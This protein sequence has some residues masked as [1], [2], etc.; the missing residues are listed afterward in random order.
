MTAKSDRKVTRSAFTLVELLVVIAIMAALLGLLLPAVQY[1]RASAR[2]TQ[3]LSQLHNIGIAMDNYMD[4]H[5]Q[6]SK[7]PDAAQLPSLVTTPKRPSL[8]VVLGPYMEQETTVYRCPSDDASFRD[9]NLL[10]A[11][12][13]AEGLT[14]FE[15]EGISYEYP[16]N[17]GS[18][19]GKRGQPLL[20]K[21]TR[22]QVMANRS[23]STVWISYDFEAY[24]GTEGEDGSRCFVYADGHADSS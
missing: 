19:S 1:A 10:T 16:A 24:H 17:T 5:G 14:Y 2:R 6:R 21:K 23:S 9:A 8:V 12:K 4:S 7:Y 11:G 18:Y 20:A 15:K 13:P 3:C 22:Q